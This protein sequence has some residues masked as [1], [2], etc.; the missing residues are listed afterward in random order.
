M[1]RAVKKTRPVKSTGFSAHLAQQPRQVGA[2]S[3]A[4]LIGI[5]D[6]RPRIRSS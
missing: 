3:K 6:D 1:R 2:E 4:I 5:R